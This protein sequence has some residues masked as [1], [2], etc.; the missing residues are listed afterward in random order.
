M[1]IDALSACTAASIR[2]LTHTHTHIR[3]FHR[4]KYPNTYTFT[5]ACGEIMLS[6]ACEG[7]PTAIVRPTI[8][9]SG[10]KDPVPGYVVYLRARVRTV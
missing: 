8:V 5:K 2:I 7:C 6:R 4:C 3:H 9:G 1:L 10:W